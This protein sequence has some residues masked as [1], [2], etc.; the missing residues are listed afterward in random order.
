MLSLGQ[1]QS[2]SFAEALQAGQ[3][4]EVE[5][6]QQDLGE[7]HGTEPR[8]RPFFPDEL[9]PGESEMRVGLRLKS[10]EEGRGL[11][12]EV[13]YVNY[14]AL[15]EL[16][17]S[18]SHPD[19]ADLLSPPIILDT[20]FQDPYFNPQ[21]FLLD[22]LAQQTLPVSCREG[23]YREFF[24]RFARAVAQ[25]ST[26]ASL[27]PA[28]LEWLAE[29]SLPESL[30]ASALAA[31][32]CRLLE[33]AVPQQENPVKLQSRQRGERYRVDYVQVDHPTKICVLT[34]NIQSPATD[35]VRVQFFREGNWLEYWRDTLIPL[36]GEG[37]FH[38][39]FPLDHPRTVSLFHGYQTMRLY[40]EPGD[41]LQIR[42]NA[43][44][45]YRDMQFAGTARVEN[46][47]LLDFYHDM[48]GDTLYRSYDDDLLDKDH[49]AYF[50]KVAS[51][52]DR[53]LAFLAR[54]A[55]ALRPGFT[56]LM[57]RS[58]QLE[59]AGTQW[60]AA[61]RFM[62]EKGVSLEPELLHRLQQ[63]ATLLYRLPRVKT[64]DFE[65]EDFLS[66]QFYLLQQA[67]QLPHFGSAADFAL[68]QLLPSKETFV[69]HAAMQLFR[70]YSE[71]GELTESSHRQLS[72]LLSIT[73]DSQLIREMM[74]FREGDRE[75]PPDIGY[76]TLSK[77]EAAPAWSF[78][79]GEGVEVALADF[80]GRKL[81]LHI[82]WADNLEDALRDV[83]ALQ[84]TPGP[85]PEIVHLLAAS[86]RDRF[87]KHTAGKPGLF[88]FV[89]PDKMEELKEQYHIDNRSNHYYLIGE[90]GTVLANH[91]D[92][93][94]ARKLRGTWETI[95]SRPA[96]TTWTPE[97]R[98]RFWQR[99]GS[100]ALFLLLISGGILWQ[101]RVTARRDRRKR[102]LLETEL[103]GIRSQMNP[104]FL[105]NAMSS[106]QNLIRK[107]EQEKADQYL[108]QF[109]GLMRKTLR[110]TAEEY[111]PL[112]DEIETLT[113]YC[114]LESL[115]Q[116]FQ[117]EFQ[118]DER[119]DAHN[120]YIPSM[121]LQPI[122]EN[123]IIHGLAPQ[124]GAR[125]LRV[126]ISPGPKGLSCTITDNGIGVLASQKHPARTNHR[127]VGM[128]LV[129]QR[130]EL[131]GLNRPEHLTIT[132][133]STLRPPAR[134]TI[135]SLTI[136][137]EQ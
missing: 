2:Q 18:S 102:Q 61:Y 53:E 106:I 74:I 62:A 75:L 109:A 33:E 101:R 122:V 129:R 5:W 14:L 96:A 23:A 107:Q 39:A 34:G 38:L 136:P 1:A 24:D 66:F 118:V 70:R 73:R 131:M 12:A 115:R 31:F 16:A 47:F 132:D 124:A 19:A 22:A 67:Y 28:Q 8:D 114:S 93:G 32:F 21:L 41:S 55:P 48:R 77:G 120:T 7:E 108:G 134:G 121:I 44:A 126:E 59:H 137:V 49:V 69:R 68:A 135:V 104:H 15:P 119:I 76:R 60:E 11:V 25:S 58:L 94:T 40:L 103:R 29:T 52:A 64:F 83:Q 10:A 57:D 117:Y 13:T 89:P 20:R 127:S 79:D 30:S 105:F 125:T 130:L 27:L 80:A 82:G 91:Y 98:L 110:N 85:L 36:D 90:D 99:L 37:N 46:A 86:G 50:Q 123:A 56:A 71:L 51:Q 111:I 26:A 54:R 17:E 6:I 97:Q 133:R 116:P 100:V 87:A 4:I 112:T 84:A 81:L 128:K 95:A 65:V 88:L 92:L 72:Q 113:Q 45:F 78:Q 3:T 42:T 9:Q 35:Q 43:N 63:K